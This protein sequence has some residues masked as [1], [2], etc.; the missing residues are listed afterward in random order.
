MIE[1]LGSELEPSEGLT[2]R[3]GEHGGRRGD[4]RIGLCELCASVRE[5]IGDR[6]LKDR[7]SD[8]R[9]VSHGGTENTEVGDRVRR[10]D[11]V[12][13]VPLLEI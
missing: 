4:R 2:R 7:N 8:H 3:H 11:S 13:F 9:R 1:D 12:N 5:L 6:G 10:S